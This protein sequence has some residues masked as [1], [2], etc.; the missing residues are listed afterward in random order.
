[1]PNESGRYEVEQ[2]AKIVEVLSVPLR[3]A[4]PLYVPLSCRVWAECDDCDE[5]LILVMVRKEAT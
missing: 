1:M 3:D 4:K 2:E 5:E